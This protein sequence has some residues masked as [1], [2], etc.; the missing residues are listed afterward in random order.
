MMT[1][2]QQ[3]RRGYPSGQQYD[4]SLGNALIHCARIVRAWMQKQHT[5][6]DPIAPL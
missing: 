2:P 3:N 6:H 4:A 5:P 1:F